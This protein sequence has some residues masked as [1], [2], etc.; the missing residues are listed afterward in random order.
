[1]TIDPKPPT[2]AQLLKVAGGDPEVVRLLE[3]L[4]KQ[5][6]EI[7]PTE[8]S[9]LSAILEDGDKG[10]ISLTI[11]GTR[12]II[13]ANAVGNAKLAKMA[14]SSIKANAS[15][16]TANALDVVIGSGQLVGRGTSGGISPITVGSGL[17]LSG[18]TLSAGFG[19]GTPLV[20]LLMGQSNARALPAAVEGDHSFDPDIWAWD[21]QM[22]TYPVTAGTQWLQATFGVAPLDI[23]VAP[24]ANNISFQ[25]ARQLRKRYG[26][27]VYF[28]SIS[29][30]E[31]EA[32][33]WIKDA[34]LAANGWTRTDQN[35]TLLMYP[36]IA[37]A[38]ALVP[39]AP[40]KLDYFLWVHGG[41]NIEEIPET[42]AA[43]VTAIATD[44][45][46]V[47]LLDINQT[48]IIVGEL[49]QDPTRT[50]RYRHL[51]SMYR[52]Q[53]N[54]PTLRIARSFGIPCVPASPVHF[55]GQGLEIMGQRME[56]L[57][58]EPTETIDYR[59]EDLEWGPDIGL[60]YFTNNGNAA[61]FDMSLRPAYTPANFL[62]LTNDPNLG[63]AFD[64]VANGV[65]IV[66]SRRIF[67]APQDGVIKVEFEA[68]TYAVGATVDMKASVWQWDKDGVSL[69][70]KSV[71]LAILTDAMGRKQYKASF[72]RSG[73]SADAT[74]DT[75][76]EYFAYGLQM[77]VGSDDEA[78][79]FNITDMRVD[80]VISA[81]GGG[82]DPLLGW[83]A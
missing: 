21:T 18:T 11:G 50:L 31:T 16:T 43:M 42:H 9:R 79:L 35:L 67:P 15:T 5:A 74:L 32:Q 33:A 75:G 36:G 8:L 44:L 59:I 47:G 60:R 34:T 12:W 66:W 61:N 1:L 40:T 41:A 55:N 56:A 28:I 6:G 37:D 38:L 29:K 23:G 58:Y 39:G 77:G 19:G 57:A 45:A 30:G 25:F 76:C 62:A 78:F 82:S 13:D 63:W 27:P 65:R 10:D 70:S 81:T 17:T 49:A 46:G 14:G 26:R 72:A 22:K 68:I 80:P 3:R 48:P 53:E 51:S 64:S 69:G 54:L 7:T 73:I 52:A 4:F 83:F 20:I 71:T 2:R 24:Y